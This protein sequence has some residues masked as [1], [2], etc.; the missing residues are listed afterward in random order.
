MKTE[1]ICVFCEWPR[2][3]NAVQKKF[4]QIERSK[5]MEHSTASA[6]KKYPKA[7]YFCGSVLS[8]TK[9]RNSV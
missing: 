5:T 4:W 2:Q 1:E 8:F 3:I 6:A 7:L 9:G